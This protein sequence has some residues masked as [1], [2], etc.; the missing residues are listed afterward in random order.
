MTTISEVP[1]LHLATLSEN[2]S[3]LIHQDLRG[4][5]ERGNTRSVDFRKKLLNKLRDVIKSF[6]E[7]LTEALAHDLR[8]PAFESYTSEIGFAYQ[9]IGHTLEKLEAWARPSE[10]EIGV[11]LWPSSAESSYFP[12]GVVLIVSPWNYP[13]NLALAPLV[14]AVAA[15]CCV[16]LK[17]AEDTPA[18][19]ALIGEIVELSFDKDHVRVVQ[20]PGGEVVSTLMDGGRFD[21][22]FYT[23]STRVGRILGERCGKELISCTLELGGK[24]PAVVMQDASLK[25]TA[26]RLVW[27]KCFNAGQTCVAPDYLLVHRSILDETINELKQAILSAYGEHTIKSPD[28]A[29]IVNDHHFDRL[30][31]L[32]SNVEVLV[33][34]QH[35]KQQ[36]FIAPTLVLLKNTDSPLMES[37]IFGP[38]LPII[39][40]DSWSDA[41]AIIAQHPNPLAGYI[42]TESKSIADRFIEEITFGGGCVNDTIIHLGVPALP[43][44]GVGQS[45][46]GRYHSDEGFKTFSNQRSIV[47]STTRV[48][49]PTRYAPYKQALMRAVKWVIN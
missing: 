10:K 7:R 40:F 48:N 36:R 27:G 2:E 1:N 17:P 39:P 44:G 25:A 24:S 18:V 29:R 45:G 9:D 20:G 30:V 15:G 34:G 13:F 6:E 16:V 47:R 11:A 43:F 14:A 12:K 38:I 46:W 21:H 28:L 8:K 33:G 49:L 41:K 5:F 42:F 26:D 23:G 19:S 31:S 3:D 4:Y 32:L 37:E 35:D 22:L